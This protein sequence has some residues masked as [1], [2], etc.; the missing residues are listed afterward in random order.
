MLLDCVCLTS[1]A[2]LAGLS[3]HGLELSQATCAW[4]ASPTA[5]GLLE[6][7]SVVS[8]LNI[9][10]SGVIDQKREMGWLRAGGKPYLLKSFLG[11]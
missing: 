5:A 2:N 7:G 8:N 1:D 6:P 11:S 9:L 10:C 4:D 3:L